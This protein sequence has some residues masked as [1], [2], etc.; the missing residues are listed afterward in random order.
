MTRARA[1]LA[2]VSILFLAPLTTHAQPFAPPS[3]TS[4]GLQS[5][6]ECTVA[7]NIAQVCSPEL[8]AVRIVIIDGATINECGNLGD[9]G[10]GTD[11][12]VCRWSNKA[13]TWVPDGGAGGGGGGELNTHSSEAGGL[14]VTATTP[15]VGVDLRL[16]ALSSTDF[17]RGGDVIFIDARWALD[18]ELHDEAHT[19]ASHSDTTGT[20]PELDNLTDGT[21]ADSLH[22][23][24]AAAHTVASHS[25]T[26]GTGPELDNLT[27]GT[28]ADSLHAHAANEANTHSSEAGGVT[29][30]A[31]T[32]K[33]GVDLRLVN[34]DSSDFTRL[35]NTVSINPATWAQLI[36]LHAEAHG[37]GFEELTGGATT[38]TLLVAPGG[39]IGPL[40]TGQVVATG[41]SGVAISN[42]AHFDPLI[43][44][45]DDPQLVTGTAPPAAVACAE[46]NADG[47]L[48]FAPAG[49][50]C[51]D[52]GDLHAQLHAIASHNDTTGTGPEL[53]ELTD[54]STTALHSHNPAGDVILESDI[55]AGLEVLGGTVNTKSDESGFIRSLGGLDLTCNLSNYGQVAQNNADV[56]QYCDSTGSPGHHFIADGDSTGAVAANQFGNADELNAAGA[57]SAVHAGGQAHH[58]EGHTAASHSDQDA[59]GPELN[60][61]TDGSNLGL[62]SPLHTHTILDADG[63]A[64]VGIGSGDVIDVVVSTNRGVGSFSGSLVLPEQAEDRTGLAAHGEFWVKDDS[65]QVPM[66]QDG[67]TDTSEQ[68][69]TWADLQASYLPLSGGE[70]D[71]PGHLAIGGRRH[72]D[73]API[74]ITAFTDAG[75]GQVIIDTAG[76]HGL[77]DGDELVIRGTTNY[78]GTQVVDGGTSTTWFL[79]AHAWDGDQADADSVLSYIR[80]IPPIVGSPDVEGGEWFVTETS[81]DYWISDFGWGC[82]DKWDNPPEGGGPQTSCL[83]TLGVACSDNICDS[84]GS[85]SAE[86]TSFG[87]VITLQVLTKTTFDCSGALHCGTNVVDTGDGDLVEFTSYQVLSGANPDATVSWLMSG[88]WKADQYYGGNFASEV[89][90]QFYSTAF[91]DDLSL[92]GYLDIGTAEWFGEGV[93]TPGVQQGTL[94]YSWECNDTANTHCVDLYSERYGGP[95]FTADGLEPAVQCSGSA[96]TFCDS[97]GLSI[98]SLAPQRT[99]ARS[100]VRLFIDT[101]ITDK[102]FVWPVTN[103][104]DAGDVVTVVDPADP[105]LDYDGTFTAE[106]CADIF[107]TPFGGGGAEQ[108]SNCPDIFDTPAVG[109]VPQTSDGGGGA[110]GLTAFAI[111]IMT[112]LFPMGLLSLSISPT[113]RS[114]TPRSN[115]T[116]RSTVFATLTRR[117]PTPTRPFP[118]LRFPISAPASTAR[119]S[120]LS[121]APTRAALTFSTCWVAAVGVTRNARARPTGFATTTAAPCCTT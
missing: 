103:A 115:I 73:P 61:L 113:T 111:L 80:R 30:T 117:L 54:G 119:C 69:A 118:R 89:S 83:P 26:T 68:L 6:V 67:D 110:D 72:V 8:N 55:G 51:L 62:F 28:N 120:T 107:D 97:D 95:C 60:F 29:L 22:A 44:T 16:V 11:E 5:P 108:T 63:P 25:D 98:P 93:T 121:R 49:E 40:S 1:V 20:G 23:H 46:W 114:H 21:N 43:L 24:V 82:V 99:L 106:L 91:L 87:Q 85:T 18:S 34:L 100:H 27:D 17:D 19:V 59:T 47:D 32:P 116:T 9:A 45:G 96:D 65:P 35:A 56:M 36:D 38:E 105:G 3:P 88:L 13:A 101:G 77:D 76:P 64:A 14:S 71:H 2:L 50:P 4:P 109:C 33:V 31:T 53:D 84:D 7:E 10:L 104:T 81:G 41:L 57:V 90:P 42:L 74:L 52:S 112:C 79:I 86:P 70:L 48:V 66:F 37:H 75:G 78:N 94:F 58:P 15:K 92:R 39:I 102:T 12:N